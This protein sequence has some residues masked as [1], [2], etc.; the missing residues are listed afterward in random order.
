MTTQLKEPI[1]ISQTRQGVQT[2]T[3][4]FDFDRKDTTWNKYGIMTAPLLQEALDGTVYADNKLMGIFRKEK[5]K[6][7]TSRKYV[8]FPNKECDLVVGDF[9]DKYADK[10]RLKLHKTHFAYN[11]DAKYWEIRSSKKYKIDT[12]DEVQLGV[13]VRN[14]LACNV[15][16]GADIFTFRLVCQNGAISKGKDLLSLKIKHYGKD[17][18]KLMQE[19]L[20]RRIHDLF[21]EGELLLDQYRIATKLKVRQ[22]AA[23]Q[24]VRKVSHKYIPE[25]I[26]WDVER[27]QVI[28]R[29][30]TVPWWKLFNDVTKSVWHNN[31]INFL[32][33]ADITNVMHSVMKN[34]ILVAAK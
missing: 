27:K 1:D 9:L 2:V 10:Y 26:E 6:R 32:T 17:S 5:I 34:E 20:T 7:L 25:Y 28:L 23:E 12:G 22:E 21:Y 11:G 15:S 19:S 18:L 13:V 4:P 8:I 30:T 3:M 14:S 31:A 24:I 29:D 33:K 16:F